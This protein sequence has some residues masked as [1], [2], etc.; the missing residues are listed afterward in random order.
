MIR[1]I[2]LTTSFLVTFNLFA[3]NLKFS[4]L[5]AEDGLS[6]AT[7]TCIAQDSTGFMWLG[8]YDG[9]SRFDGYNL[10]YLE[11][12]QVILFQLVMILIVKY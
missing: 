4:Q 7:A 12:I 2:L 6:Q 8:I 10:K 1:I 9:L 11:M 5:T 3:K